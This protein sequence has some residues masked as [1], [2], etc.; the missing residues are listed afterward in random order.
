[1][2]SRSLA[3]EPELVVPVPGP[4]ENNEE[5]WLLGLPTLQRFL[6]FYDDLA[7]D[8]RPGR[9]S[10]LIRAWRSANDHFSELTVTEAGFADGPEVLDLDPALDPLAEEVANDSRFK[11]SFRKLPT[12]FAMVELDRVMIGHPYVSLDHVERLRSL[13]GPAHDPADLFRFC[14]P[15][16]RDEAP[17][18]VRELGSKRYLLWSSSADFRFMESAVLRPDQVSGFDAFGAVGAVVGLFVGYGSNFLNVL[19]VGDR[20]LLHNG[21]H[22]AY[23]L[24]AL[25]FTHAPSIIQTVQGEEELDLTAAR[26][27]RE[28]PD[29][30]FTNPRPPVL[31]DFFNPVFRL[32]VPAHRMMNLVEISLETKLHKKV[33]HFSHPG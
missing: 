33:R 25:G 9:R 10:E 30:Y 4:K 2:E 22:R 18:E 14:L 8:D 20:L 27:V 28:N 12:R 11:R 26:T 1:M 15:L 24:R 17:V 19:E 32:V 3:P 6:D 29:L 16:D 31:K 13:I 21:H 5:L 7:I 23:T